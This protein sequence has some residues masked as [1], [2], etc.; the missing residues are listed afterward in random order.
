MILKNTKFRRP[1][2][3]VESTCTRFTK[4]GKTRPM[5]EKWL[6][7]KNHENR[8]TCVRSLL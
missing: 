4:L 8:D 7:Q 3:D 2:F 1:S 6:S 5:K